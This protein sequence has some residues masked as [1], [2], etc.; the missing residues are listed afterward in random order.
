MRLII[1]AIALSLAPSVGVLA[2]QHRPG[3]TAREARLAR[4]YQQNAGQQTEQFSRRVKLGRDGRFSLANVAGDITVTG[5]SGDEVIIEAT[6]RTRDCGD[7]GRVTIEVDARAGR[8][9]VRT[10]YADRDNRTN[11]VSVSYTVTVPASTSVDLKSVSG[12]VK[13]TSIQ[14]AV[15]AESVSGNVQTASSAKLEQAK[16]VSGD[17]DFADVATDGD[18]AVTSVSGNVRGRNLRVRGLDLSTVSGDVQLVNAACDRL[19]FRSVSG[20]VDYSGSLARSGRYDFNSHSGNIRLA[21]PEDAGFELIGSSFSGSIRSDLPLSFGSDADPGRR[22]RR[23]FNRNSVR[24]TFGDGSAVLTVRTF[25]G[26]VI[27]VKR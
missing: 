17:I 27:I 13:T 23:G 7:L 8:V 26:D 22:P 19:G 24:G 16:S 18:L 1:T 5:G 21:L 2:G 3:Y 25:S 6:K 15:R 11:Q 14:G 10:V 12:N 4:A 9:D 20:G